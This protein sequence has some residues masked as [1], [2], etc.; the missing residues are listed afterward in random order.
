M[1]V[2]VVVMVVVVLVVVVLVVLVVVVTTASVVPWM[3]R[4]RVVSSPGRV[5][6]MRGRGGEMS[7]SSRPGKKEM[8]DREVSQGGRGFG[9]V[10]VLVEVS[11]TGDR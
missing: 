7:R 5:S 8:G 1:V 2:V 11:A 3:P 9:V 4:G 6:G 10:L